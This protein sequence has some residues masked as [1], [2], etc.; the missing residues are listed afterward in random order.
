MLGQPAVER[1]LARRALERG[2]DLRYGETVVA[3]APATPEKGLT[4]DKDDI[5]SGQE[6]DAVSERGVVVTTERGRTV[7]ARCVVGADGARSTVRRAA[8]ITFRQDV[9][10]LSSGAGMTWA[11]M[12]A[13][14]ETDF[15]R[16]AEII[17]FELRGRTR[18]QWIPRERG[19][20]RFYALMDEGEEVTL[21]GAVAC[22]KDHLAPHWVEFK[23]VEWFSS[24]RG[25]SVEC[26]A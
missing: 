20:A 25:E 24:V 18:V 5:P 4:C 2:V 16:C 14:V 11:V 26:S 15:P 13:F 6:E 7:R 17:S 10:D 12:D 21:D 8:G 22:I 19:L 3:S 1:A 9:G 23:S